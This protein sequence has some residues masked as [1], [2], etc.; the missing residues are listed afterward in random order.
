MYLFSSIALSS[1]FATVVAFGTDFGFM[2]PA[3]LTR[4]GPKKEVEER[5][6][7]VLQSELDRW[8]AIDQ[9]IQRRL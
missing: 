3:D 4:E 8:E 9:M 6:S 1:H 5:N 2:W 7:R